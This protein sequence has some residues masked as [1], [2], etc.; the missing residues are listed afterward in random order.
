MKILN[1]FK[2]E[3]KVTSKSNI[4]ILDK[5]QIKKVIGGA[6]LTGDGG[7]NTGAHKRPGPA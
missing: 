7:V 3:K 1:F 4:Q 5:K 6:D 2:K